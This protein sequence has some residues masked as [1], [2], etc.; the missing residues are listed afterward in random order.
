MKSLKEWGINFKSVK[1]AVKAFND[2]NLA[3]TTIST[4]GVKGEIV[5]L[6]LIK[7]IDAL[8]DD[9]MPLIPSVTQDV[10]K[11]LPDDIFAMQITEEEAAEVEKAI[12][13]KPATA[14][15]TTAPAVEK[16]TTK[17]RGPK[18]K[19][20][21]APPVEKKKEKKEK[22]E[23]P[24][25]VEAE[26]PAPEDEETPEDTDQPY[27]SDCPI[28]GKGFNPKEAECQACNRDHH[29]DYIHCKRIVSGI[30]LSKKVKAKKKGPAKS[31]VRAATP[32]N[33]L[34]RY[35]HRL[36]SMTAL[37]D[38]RLWEGVELPKLALE[39]ADWFSRTP[40]AAKSKIKAHIVH[41]TRRGIQ[42]T[43]TPNTGFY[44]ANVEYTHGQNTENTGAP[45]RPTA[46]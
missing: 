18:P 16:P 4:I 9:K 35:G 26:T 3:T 21:T 45:V 43:I 17:R 5:L 40:D 11:S 31:R 2:A 24:P 42:F 1:D 15:T 10:Y 23:N 29:Q 14:E 33:K 6:A 34:S 27:V 28:F 20:E 8:E 32:E 19:E 38:E 30:N 12:V 7:A 36:T 41:L 22:K 46:E 44:K 25:K 39:V 13:E 37:I